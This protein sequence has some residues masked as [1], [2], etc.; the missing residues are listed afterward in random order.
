MQRDRA[1][2]SPRDDDG[3]VWQEC[4]DCGLLEHPGLT[5]IDA[6]E[7]IRGRAFR[8]LLQRIGPT[9]LSA[10]DDAAE[11]RIE[12]T[13]FSCIDCAHVGDSRAYLVRRGDIRQLTSDHTYVAMQV[14]MSL[15]SKQEAMSS[16]LR[17]VL[18]R[19]IGQNPTIQVDYAR[20]VL[21]NHDVIVQCTD[22]LHAFV[23]RHPS[24]S[25]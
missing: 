2:D 15:I 21:E 1:Q 9:L 13:E 7:L 5:C 25:R 24:H 12:R 11:D 4:D 6:A 10:L 3:A 16:E 17:G 22:G 14:K 8:E 20:K 23:G 19:S 18:T